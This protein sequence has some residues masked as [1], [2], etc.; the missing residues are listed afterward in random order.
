MSGYGATETGTV[1]AVDAVRTMLNARSVA[2]VGASADESKFSGQPLRNLRNAG[3]DGDIHVVNKSGGEVLGVRALS[4][5]AELPTGVD[6]GFV[7][8]PARHVADTVA[9]LGRAGV[10]T[11][12]VAVS[13]F[14][15]MGTA[16]STELQERL[17]ETARTHGVRVLG[18][19]CNGIYNATAGLPLG[20]NYTHSRRLAPG[21][22]G[23]VSHSGAMLGGFAPRLQEYGQGL[24]C[25]VS[26]G[27]EV[28]L[29]LVDVL[30]Y[31]VDDPATDVIALI[32]DSVGDGARFRE[33]VRAARKRGKQVAALKLGNSPGGVSATEAHSSRLAG[34]RSAYRA[35]FAA[36]GVVD[37]PSLETLALTCA[38]LGADRSPRHDGVVVTST[39][40]AGGIL[41]ADALSEVGIPPPALTERTVTGMRPT[42]GFARVQNPFDIGAA[43]NATIDANLRALAGDPAAGSLIAYLTPAPTSS[44]RLALAR[45]TADVADEHPAMPI[46]V[47]SPAPPDEDERHVYA[48]AGIPV[49][50]SLLDAVAVVRAVSD[51]SPRYERSEAVDPPTDPAPHVRSLSEPA[52]KRLL[53]GYGITFPD[54]VLA[55]SVDDAVAA[56]RDLGYPVVLKAAG[57][58]FVHKT[59]HELVVLDVPDRDSLRQ[60]YL[61]LA[62]RARRL[63][64]LEGVLV[65]QQVP[66]GVDVM[67]G[68]TIDPEFGPL[69]VCGV[70]GTMTE[71][72]ADVATA[73]VPLARPA[74]ERLLDSTRVGRLL[75]GYRGTPNHDRD[76]LITQ[77]L[78]LSAAADDLRDEVTAVD[79]NPVRVLPGR[80]GTVALDAVVMRSPSPALPATW[81]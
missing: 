76:A 31:L 65:A 66:E 18:P 48:A 58:D 53:A 69:V 73:P 15:E 56:A 63:G 54:E 78:R 67:L 57:S 36:D 46:V 22:V 55:Y 5:A 7:M 13:G 70:G 52:S 10:P 17:A 24:S 28:D 14:A 27:N 25:F 6:V 12:V 45:A 35:V 9:D 51:V 79:L 43:G 59:D 42:A 3:Y 64:E 80:G 21:S 29:T 40:G 11:A 61:D 32:L 20:Y 2:L 60:H 30:E 77:L 26:T 37:V 1:H 72:V 71:L 81:R 8:V 44:W 38:L 34:S 75:G 74:A 49:V 16:E 19:N 50:G 41:A 4:S 62:E 47:V 39:S 33:L 68:V 23:L